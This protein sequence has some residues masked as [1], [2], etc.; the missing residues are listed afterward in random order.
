VDPPA[1][2]APPVEPPVEDLPVKTRFQVIVVYDPGSPGSDLQPNKR[3]VWESASYRRSFKE[4]VRADG[5]TFVAISQHNP[6][7]QTAAWNK[8]LNEAGGIP[9]LVLIPIGKNKV[10]GTMYLPNAMSDADA[11][12]IVKRAAAK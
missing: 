1:P 8:V 5:H 12:K 2:P 4:S 6:Q 10:T 3:S 9:A 11:L 7:V